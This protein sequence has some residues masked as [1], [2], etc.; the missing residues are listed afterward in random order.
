MVGEEEE[1]VGGRERGRGW[2]FVT[3]HLLW[4]SPS[5]GTSGQDRPGCCAPISEGAVPYTRPT[6]AP[7]FHAHHILCSWVHTRVSCKGSEKS[8]SGLLLSQV[9]GFPN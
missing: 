4:L 1:E 2:S 6:R 5:V 9:G 7:G 8:C 3:C